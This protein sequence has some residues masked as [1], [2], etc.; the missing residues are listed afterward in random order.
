MNSSTITLVEHFKGVVTFHFSNNTNHAQFAG[1]PSVYE[2]RGA[3]VA[4]DPCAISDA[5]RDGHSR[6]IAE[7]VQ[8]LNAG[9]C[10]DIG[11]LDGLPVYYVNGDSYYFWSS[12]LDLSQGDV[13]TITMQSP[14]RRYNS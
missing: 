12:A 4:C 7:F 3:A 11:S 14:E 13:T 10:E 1:Q 2:C 5:L 9:L 8:S 6:A